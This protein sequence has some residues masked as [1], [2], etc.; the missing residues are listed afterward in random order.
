MKTEMRA[1][2]WQNPLHTELWAA[3]TEALGYLESQRPTQLAIL[4]RTLRLIDES[5]DA[6]ESLAGDDV[7]ARICGLTL[8]KAKHLA[9]GAYSLI[10]D[11]LGQESGGLL[12]PFIEYVEL[13][14]YLRKNPEMASRAAENDLPKAGERAKAIGGIYKDFRSYLNSHASHSSYSEYALSHLLEPN[15]FRFKKLQ[16]AVPQVLDANVRDYAIQIYLLAQESVLSLE[17]IS[18]T[19]FEVLATQTD[20]LRIDLLQAFELHAEQHRP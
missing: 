9:L 17:R 20:Q 7:Y 1:E 5:V 15:T 18:P 2:H 6:Y 4:L 10:L 16:R 13:L 8:L 3:R 19:S 14:T 12:R 11:G